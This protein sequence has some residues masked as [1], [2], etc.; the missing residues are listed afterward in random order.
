MYDLAPL[1]ANWNANDHTVHI[2]PIYHLNE[3][4]S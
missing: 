1:F 3:D 2:D 4:F